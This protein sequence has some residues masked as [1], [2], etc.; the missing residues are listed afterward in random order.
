MKSISA[1][2]L[3]QRPAF[4]APAHTPDGSGGA[5]RTWAHQC[6][7]WAEFIYGSGSETMNAARLQG[8]F[9]FKVRVRSSTATRLIT[10]EWRMRDPRR[11]LPDGVGADALPG[12]RY[13]IRE[14]DAVT[15]RAWVYLVVEAGVAV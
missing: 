9:T 1:S 6:T 11:G 3:T 12:T 10:T 2:R 15:D 14:V 7:V 8:R 5:T 13:N 4:D